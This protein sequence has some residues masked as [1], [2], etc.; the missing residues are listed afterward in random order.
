MSDT[1]YTR[2][3][4]A[5]K[6]CVCAKQKNIMYR[7][8]QGAGLL[9]EQMLLC[10]SKSA[11][12]TGLKDNKLG[13]PMVG[14]YVSLERPGRTKA[15]GKFVTI[16]GLKSPAKCDSIEFI[17]VTDSKKAEYP[18]KFFNIAIC[19]IGCATK[20]ECPYFGKTLRANIL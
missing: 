9:Q 1:L 6:P 15:L 7:L 11:R 17:K 12:L 3:C 8:T 14:R 5:K 13:C 4:L 16:C 18:V 20:N 19:A 10:T 2:K